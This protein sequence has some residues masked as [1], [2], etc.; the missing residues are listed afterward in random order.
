[1]F[2]FPFCDGDLANVEHCTDK[3]CYESARQAS[4]SCERWSVYSDKVMQCSV[5]QAECGHFAYRRLCAARN[6]ECSLGY[7]FQ[8]AHG[9]PVLD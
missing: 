4:R 1:M 9:A 6:L 5:K 3:K 7:V 8:M 2:L